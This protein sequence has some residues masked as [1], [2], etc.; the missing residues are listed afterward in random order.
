MAPFKAIFSLVLLLVISGKLVQSDKTFN[1]DNQCSFTVWLAA[2]SSIADFDPERGPGTTLKIASVPDTW[3]GSIWARTK[4]SFNPSMTKFSCETGDCGN[5][6]DCQSPPPTP[7]VTLL[8]FGISQNV[9]SYEVNLNHGFNVPVRIQPVRGSLVGGSRPCPVVDCIKDLKD[10]CPAQLAAGN[11]NGAYVGCNSPCDALKDPKYCCTGSFSGS[12]CQPN[13]FSRT[14]KQV[15]QLAHT[16]PGDND[17]PI[18]QCS[19]AT[20][21]NITFCPF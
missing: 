4:C 13:E 10:V 9:V 5:G 14:F 11:S 3:T 8:N 7:P 15:C 1:F 16:F 21:Y 2:S 19:G 18:Y 17:P 6:I 12:A 20:A